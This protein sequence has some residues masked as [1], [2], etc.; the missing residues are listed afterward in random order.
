[1]VDSERLSGPALRAFENIAEAWNLR[2]AERRA[3]LGGIPATS[4]DRIRARGARSLSAD[5]L[6][7]I[8]HVLGIYKALHVIFANDAY[9]DRWVREPNGAFGGDTALARMLA[10]FSS[11]VAVRQYL[12]GVRGG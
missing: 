12:D 9:A 11:L 2:L 10:G 6:E 8:S 7:R 3:L 4:Y 1:M 5:T